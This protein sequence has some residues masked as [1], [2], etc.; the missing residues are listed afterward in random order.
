[1]IADLFAAYL[2]DGAVPTPPAPRAGYADFLSWL[3]DRDGA[4]ARD[5][6]RDALAPLDG[7]T[8]LAPERAT[9]AETPAEY[10]VDLDPELVAGLH[11]FS[12]DHGVTPSTAIQVAWALTLSRLTGRQVVAFGE[13]VSGRPAELD[14][15]EAAIGLF[16]NTI[17][18]IVDCDPAQTLGEVA[19]VLQNAKTR[20]LDHQHLGLADIGEIAGHP[21][22]F[23]TLTVYESYP[24]DSDALASGSRAA[25]LD[26]TG[27]DFADSTHYPLNLIV[28]PAGD[29][30]RFAFTY[31]PSVVGDD[32][33]VRVADHVH[34]VLATLVAVPGRLIADVDTISDV[35]RA[36]VT[37]WAHGA[38]VG[39][40]DGLI[41]DHVAA[42]VRATP[43]A[44]AL[45]FG[46]DA[47]TYARFGS[48]VS[49]LARDLIARGVGPEVAVG[50]CIPRSAELLVALHAVLAAGGHY[51]PIDPDAPADRIGYMLDTSGAAL[52]LVTDDTARV[53]GAQQIDVVTVPSE[54]PDT[55]V[56]PVTDADRI[57]ALRGESPAYTL[58]TSGSTGRPKGVTVT[59]EAIANRLA[60]MQASYPLDAG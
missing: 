46:G 60:W 17:P 15:V 34:T 27:V 52:V 25:G 33:V 28:G 35:D 10:D 42:Q 12:R 7:P 22:L 43:D 51:V 40:D 56:A 58:F 50:V 24:V 16:I 14:G 13:T 47:V 44:T 29:G 6:W 5:A 18:V 8:L 41:T 55:T 9:V 39:V 54:A 1:M 20:L 21:V 23:D 38:D 45:V 32:D 36:L 4:A 59:H 3:A 11:R 26:I 2:G 31:L 19:S 30:M 49:A 48:R 37:G 53:P 57:T